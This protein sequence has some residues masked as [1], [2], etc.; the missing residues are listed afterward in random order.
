[1]ADNEYG[2][3]GIIVMLVAGFVS[4]IGFVVWEKWLAPVNYMRWGL[5]RD[6]NLIGGCLVV[7]ASVGSVA[8]WDAY[9]SSYLQVVHDQSITVAGYI[10]NAYM[11]LFAISAPF[12]GLSIP[13]R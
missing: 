12:F 9:Y 7:L 8:S 6:R 1:M 5:M 4:M 11:L 13:N 2:N 3:T 10:T